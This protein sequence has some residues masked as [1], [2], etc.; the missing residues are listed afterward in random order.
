MSVLLLLASCTC[1]QS[2]S[3]KV[4]KFEDV[5]R[6]RTLPIWPEKWMSLYHLLCGR[7]KMY[8]FQQWFNNSFCNRGHGCRKVLFASSIHRKE[9]WV[10]QF[11]IF[12]LTGIFIPFSCLFPSCMSLVWCLSYSVW[13]WIALGHTFGLISADAETKYW[14]S[15]GKTC[16]SQSCLWGVGGLALI[17]Q[18]C[19]GFWYGQNEISSL[20]FA[21]VQYWCSLITSSWSFSAVKEF[22]RKKR[23]NFSL[24]PFCS[25]KQPCRTLGLPWVMVVRAYCSLCHPE[26]FS[27]VWYHQ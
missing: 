20:N 18:L 10:F 26:A 14:C 7:K 13:V 21:C 15:N 6:D 8:L 24:S 3:G 25:L 12:I 23:N 17:L 16:S 19:C 11:I 22:R 1:N 2:F 9:V 4:D 27:H 5:A